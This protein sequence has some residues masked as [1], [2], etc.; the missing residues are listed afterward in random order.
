VSENQQKWKIK[1]DRGQPDI[2]GDIPNVVSVYA[3]V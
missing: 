1:L 2:D 3:P